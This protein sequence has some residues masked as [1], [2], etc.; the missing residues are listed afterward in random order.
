MKT[1]GELAYDAYHAVLLRRVA[2]HYKQPWEELGN[3]W[4]EA[5]EAA[6]LEVL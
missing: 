6:A 2:G 1:L 4:K 5:W 3:A